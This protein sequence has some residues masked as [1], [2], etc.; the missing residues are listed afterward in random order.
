M[1]WVSPKLD[2]GLNRVEKL[3]GF[4][5]PIEKVLKCAETTKISLHSH[6]IPHRQ[7]LA[8]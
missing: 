7:Y 6:S 1:R 8:L 2:I 4:R 3:T 5:P